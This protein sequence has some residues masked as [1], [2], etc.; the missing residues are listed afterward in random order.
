MAESELPGS[1]R[2]AGSGAAFV[3]NTVP[4]ELLPPTW[5][6]GSHDVHM[7]KH[8]WAGFTIGKFRLEIHLSYGDLIF[9][10]CWLRQLLDDIALLW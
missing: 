4:F 10:C 1:G 3:S 6:E 2:P 5:F 8:A 9:G 7:L